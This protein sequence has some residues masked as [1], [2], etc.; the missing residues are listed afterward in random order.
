MAGKAGRTERVQT[1]VLVEVQRE[2]IRAHRT[3]ER[4]HELA[5]TLAPYTLDCADEAGSLR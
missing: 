4:H 2:A 3:L 1:E 5:L